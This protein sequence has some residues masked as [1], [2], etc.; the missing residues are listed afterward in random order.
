MA[1]PGAMTVLRNNALF[2]ELATPAL[3][4]LSELCTNRQYAKGEILFVQ[5]DVGDSLY[6]VV[7]GEVRISANSADGQEMHLNVIRPGE[8][9]GEI[10]LLDG[11][12]RSATAATTK[13]STIF[14]LPRDAFLSLLDTEPG[15]ASHLL[16]LLVQRVRWTSDIIEDVV[17]RSVPMRLAR[18]LSIL[19]RLHGE[20]TDEGV[21]LRLSQNDLARFLH[22][23]R[24]VVNANLQQWQKEGVIALARGALV[25]K[26]FDGLE[27]SSQ[28]E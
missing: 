25:V 16:E 24:Q 22:V 5:G 6:G 10:A 2:R 9:V 13:A 8:V 3:T 14:R 11:G 26:D 21:V 18:R 15:F 1:N 17:F 27:A 20:P 7:A 12:Q 19:A 4:R 23:S 28:E